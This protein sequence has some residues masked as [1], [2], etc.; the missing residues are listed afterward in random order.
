MGSFSVWHWLIF[1]IWITVFQYPIWRIVSKAGYSGALSLL[2]WIPLLN[3]ILLWVF[4]LS[5][6][7]AL[8]GDASTTTK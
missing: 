7:P 2:A 3:I 8:R 4:A 5:S 1:L 6:W